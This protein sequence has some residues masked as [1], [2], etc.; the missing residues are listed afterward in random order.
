MCGLGAALPIDPFGIGFIISL[1]GFLTA[2]PIY[3]LSTYLSQNKRAGL[4][5]AATYLFLIIVSAPS[6]CLRSRNQFPNA[7]SETKSTVRSARSQE[8]RTAQS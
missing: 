5:A 3:G 1:V 8:P 2:F 6:Y 7:I 4:L